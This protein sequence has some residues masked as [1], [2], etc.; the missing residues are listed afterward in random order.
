MLSLGTL[1]RAIIAV[2]WIVLA[3]TTSG[4]A[5]AYEEDDFEGN[6]VVEDI[7]MTVIFVNEFPDLSIEVFW[8]N[9]QALEDDPNRRKFEGELAP[10]GG[11]LSVETFLGHGQVDFVVLLETFVMRVLIFFIFTTLQ[12][13][14]MFYPTEGTTWSPHRP[15]A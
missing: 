4:I 13:S 14:A 2:A 12:N 15:T 11:R 1:N 8:E 3:T 6:T 5:D 7:P 10:R 9:H